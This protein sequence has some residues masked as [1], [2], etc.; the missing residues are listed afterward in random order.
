MHGGYPGLRFC[1]LVKEHR[2][3]AFDVSKGP[4]TLGLVNGGK[5]DGA[6]ACRLVVVA[7]YGGMPSVSY[8]RKPLRA[9]SHSGTWCY[10]TILN[11]TALAN[12]CTS[13]CHFP[14]IRS[15]VHVALWNGEQPGLMNGFRALN[16]FTSP[17]CPPWSRSQVHVAPPKPGQ[18]GLVNDRGGEG[19]LQPGLV[20]DRGGGGARNRGLW[21]IGY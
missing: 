16:P 15:Q 5:D 2:D 1:R 12:S 9:S 21:A 11:K 3:K 8:Y 20:N 7:Y 6:C 19:S 18:P 13:P 10:M 4:F 14:Y 17:C